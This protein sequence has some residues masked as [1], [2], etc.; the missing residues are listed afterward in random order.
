[1]RQILP[2]IALCL[3]TPPALGPEC[4]SLATQLDMTLCEGKKFDAADARLNAIYTRLA[5]KVTAAGKAKLVDAQR[6]WIKYRDLQCA[7]DTFGTNGGSINGMMIAQ[8]KTQMTLDQTKRLDHQLN[9]EEGDVSCG[10]Q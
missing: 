5:A 9:C 10:G 2:L 3:A 7:F 1:M 4:G 8:C 6:A